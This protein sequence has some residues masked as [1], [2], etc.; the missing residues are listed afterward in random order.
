MLGSKRAPNML[1]K[2]AP[3]ISQTTYHLLY[4]S[5]PST[6]EPLSYF[7]SLDHFFGCLDT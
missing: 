2:I 6:F 1:N 5:I 4:N 7:V 3:H